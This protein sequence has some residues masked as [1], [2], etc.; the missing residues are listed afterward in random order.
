MQDTELTGIRQGVWE[1]I[2]QPATAFG[3][4]LGQTR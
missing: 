3:D 4:R 1:V 2:L